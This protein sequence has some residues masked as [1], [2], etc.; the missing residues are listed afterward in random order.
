MMQ[1]ELAD[2]EISGR[3]PPRNAPH[4]LNSWIIVQSSIG[5][6]GTA[7]SE[8]GGASSGPALCSSP[9]GWLNLPNPIRLSNFLPPRAN[10]LHSL[11]IERPGCDQLRIR[12]PAF[13]T[14]R[15]DNR[16]RD[17]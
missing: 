8:A 16:R 15:A 2:P 7:Q 14:G 17:G 12:F 9:R 11:G 1:A 6:V 4:L 10:R 5:G 13:R 3:L